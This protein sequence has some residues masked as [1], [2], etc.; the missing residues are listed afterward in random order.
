MCMG[1]KE[2]EG[3]SVM[4]ATTDLTCC[5]DSRA[6]V[7]VV[8]QVIKYQN[9]V[10]IFPPVQNSCRVLSLI[11]ITVKDKIKCVPFLGVESVSSWDVSETWTS[12]ATV[13]GVAAADEEAELFG[14]LYDW[15]PKFCLFSFAF[16]S[17]L[18]KA[19]VSHRS[20]VDTKS[21]QNWQ[22]EENGHEDDDT[23]LET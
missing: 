8:T 1:V 16:A 22:Q 6:N 7:S 17:S 3:A 23:W 4:S 20:T 10:F 15:L 12:I 11:S 14:G 9:Y 21:L 13:C 18:S 2:T 19:A 5:T